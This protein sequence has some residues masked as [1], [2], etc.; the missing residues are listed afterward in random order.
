MSRF[1]PVQL[2]NWTNGRLIQTAINAGDAERHYGGV[3]K[4]TRTLKQGDVYV[5]LVGPNF[6]GHDFAMAA[7][8]KGAKALVLAE[9]SDVAKRLEKQLLDV[10][11]SDFDLVL[12]EDT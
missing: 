11:D 1:I 3:S 4:D 9:G 2:K 6:D 7:L 5:A 10:A 12:V 8:Q